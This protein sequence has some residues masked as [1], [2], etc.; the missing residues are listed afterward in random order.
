MA[1]RAKEEKPAEPVADETAMK[2]NHSENANEHS[3]EEK[4][5][6]EKDLSK[7]NIVARV[8]SWTGSYL[9]V[10]FLRDGKPFTTYKGKNGSTESA[11]KALEDALKSED[12]AQS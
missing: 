8:V 12:K 6:L 10:K 5:K 11:E 9:K 2:L 3:T 1:K 4:E 7:D